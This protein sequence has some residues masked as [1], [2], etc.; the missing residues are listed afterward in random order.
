M[1]TTRLYDQDPYLTEFPA[2]IVDR[3]DDG[4]RIYLDRTAFYPASG[5]QPH[6]TGAI[7]GVPVVEVIDEGRRIAHLTASP[8]EG[9]EAACR[10][11]W[12]RRFDHM[13]QHTGQH[14]LSAVL[15]EL[16]GAATVSFHLGAEVSTIELAVDALRPEQLLA[17]EE[18]ANHHVTGN[19]PVTAAYEAA[20]E[21]TDL[22]R[23]SGR[24]GVLRIVSIEG[25]DRSACGGT[26]V[27]ATGEIGPMLL[28]KQ[29]RI[30]GNVRLEFLCGMRAVRRARQDFDALASIARTFSSTLDD[31]PALAGAQRDALR[32]ARKECRRLEG[33]LALLRGRQMYGSTEPDGS[34]V[35]RAVERRASGAVDEELRTLAQGF[36]AQPKAMLVAAIEDPPAVLVAV[37]QDLRLDA[38]AILKPLLAKHGGRG[39]GTA[40]L[41][42]GSLPSRQALDAV[43]LELG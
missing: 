40:R 37:S 15:L 43:L 12:E 8:V 3:G 4:R 41:A 13:Q 42:Q 35:R 19:R 17:A 11:D 33:E 2:R 27:R 30:R 34:G 9:V 29:E 23:P 39:G 21:A 31:A 5:G 38:A 10:I 36:T 28:R 7:S 22:R 26:H 6:D 25:L 18:R 16:C 14:L 32:S 1:I 20:S 24:E